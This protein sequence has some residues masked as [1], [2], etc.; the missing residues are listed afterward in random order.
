[1]C[2]IPFQIRKGG[3]AHVQDSSRDFRT[4]FF[5]EL[6]D[7]TQLTTMILAA[8]SRSPVAVFVGAALALA[9]SALGVLL[10]EFVTRVVPTRYIHFGA[11]VAFMAIGA[12]LISG[13]L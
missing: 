9:V 8:Q 10:G 11:G 7:K 13:R 2:G 4:G 1:M 5:A 12:L 6:G 3:T